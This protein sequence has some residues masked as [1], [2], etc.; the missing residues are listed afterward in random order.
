MSTPL[1]PG[2]AQTCVHFLHSETKLTKPKDSCF[3]AEP[4]VEVRGPAKRRRKAQ[5][6]RNDFHAGTQ[7]YP[8]ILHISQMDLSFIES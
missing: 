2:N 6:L 4:L 1:S 3:G 7:I 8:A 5:N